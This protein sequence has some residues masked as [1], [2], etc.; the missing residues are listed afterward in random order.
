[1]N[2]D[3]FTAQVLHN[4]D[5][6]DARHAGIYSVCGLAMRLRDLY[7]WER[8]LPPWREDEPSR[9]LAW[10]GEKEERW[11]SLMDSDYRPLELDGKRL[12]VFD[13][14]GVN[15]ILNPHG[16]YYG[17]GYA[18]SLKPTFFV[19]RILDRQQ[20]EGHTVWILGEESARDL[21]T[22]PAFSQ[23]GQAVLRTEAS[24]MFLW[25]QIAYMNN[26]GRRAL[27][28]ALEAAG[29]PDD[30]TDTIKAHF[31]TLWDLQKEIYVYHEVGE[32]EEKLF[33]RTTWRQMLADYAH[34]P[35]EMLI[36]TLKDLLADSSPHGALS[37]IVQQQNSAALGLYLAFGKGFFPMLC[38]DLICAFDA[39]VHTQVWE[40]I[41]RTVGHIRQTAAG[42]A[43]QVMD[44]H[45]QGRR[46]SRGA[47]WCQKAI[48]NT[49]RDRGMLPASSIN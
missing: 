22:L 37:H 5:V 32:L 8:R 3:Q 18:H 41:R 6:S 35:V 15:R 49:M 40:P 42:Y 1:M 14:A 9:V 13:A 19:A 20:V 38:P 17:A 43:R 39:F 4:C 27:N 11:E 21:L 34:T 28:F 12:D 7:K 24:R 29:I 45:A 10:I 46:Q 16:L 36:R 33:D 23:D 25:D 44:L 48:E 31:N 30:S 47:A 26:T 2:F